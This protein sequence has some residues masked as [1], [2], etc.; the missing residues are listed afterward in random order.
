MA[1][2]FKGA[3]TVA[4]QNILAQNDNAYFL[5]SE[6]ETFNKS[7]SINGVIQDINFSAENFQ[8]MI[9]NRIRW[10]ETLKRMGWSKAAVQARIRSYY[11]NKRSLRSSWDM[12][13]AESSPSAR[14]RGET[15]FAIARRLMKI[16]RVKSTFGQAY[17]HMESHTIPQGKNIPRP[18]K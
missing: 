5:E 7:T 16:S 15:D 6:I 10:V 9:R 18:P 8:N 12:V 13:Q 14:Q 1:E 17:T 3:L 2:R 4:E 11:E